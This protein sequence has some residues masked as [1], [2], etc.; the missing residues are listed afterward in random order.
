MGSNSALD[1]RRP[2]QA[3]ECACLSAVPPPMTQL[4]FYTHAMDEPPKFDWKVKNR[5][6]ELGAHS[7]LL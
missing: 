6:S 3:V 5:T 7:P 1:A 4:D 2:C